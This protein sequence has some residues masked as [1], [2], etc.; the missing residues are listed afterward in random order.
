MIELEGFM[1]I[2]ILKE[3]GCSIRQIAEE[4]CVAR[5]TVRKYLRTGQVPKYGP[6]KPRPGKLEPFMVYLQERIEA[7]RPDWIPAT[8]LFR[9]IQARGYTGSERLVRYYL[10]ELRPRAP[11]EPP[12]RFETEPARQMQ[13]DWAVFRRGRRPLSAFTATLGFSRASY[14]EFVSDERANTL[15]RCHEHAFR[16]FGGV[17]REVLYDNAKAVVVQRDAYGEGRH[18]FHAG[19]WDTAG[20]Y[21]FVPR[22]CQPYRA[23]TKGKVERFIRYMRHSFYV[24][25]KARLH[26]AGLQLDV[27]T[28]NAEVLKWLRDVANVRTHQTTKARP[29]DR[30]EQERP[31][32]LPLPHPRAE[33]VPASPAAPG[34]KYPVEPIQRPL[35]VY[36]QLLELQ[37]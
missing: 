5:N 23:R 32:L 25:L 3:Q 36:E 6:R 15:R 12:N 34:G 21:G 27:E 29:A 8:V 2:K 16:Y 18:R 30:L 17:P 7:A 20:H 4:L 10:S 35:S 28:A 31:L 22:L 1:K 14:V 9:E 13:V 37:P 33:V 19:L 26:A 11:E 24:P